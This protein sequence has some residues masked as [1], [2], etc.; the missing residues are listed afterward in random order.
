MRRGLGQRR[1]ASRA[2]D[3]AG[4]AAMDGEK[5]LYVAGRAP[6]AGNC[7]KSDAL[8]TDAFIQVWKLKLFSVADRAPGAGNRTKSDALKIG[9]L[10]QAWKSNR[11]PPAGTERKPNSLHR[12]GITAKIT[13]QYL[14]LRKRVADPSPLPAAFHSVQ[15]V[16]T[17]PEYLGLAPQV[18]RTA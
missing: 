1:K 17:P 14:R 9:A 2:M 8:K 10:M 12:I 5:R 16:V 18:C 3:G 13:H 15:S 11:C 4:R 6:G 7:T